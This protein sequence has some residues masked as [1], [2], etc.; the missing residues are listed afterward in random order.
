M[1]LANQIVF[2]IKCK[3]ISATAETTTGSDWRQIR[4]SF[5]NFEKKFCGIEAIKNN[6]QK[7]VEGGDVCC[8][9]VSAYSL[10]LY[11]QSSIAMA[12]LS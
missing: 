8:I 4:F 6:Y 7:L 9:S 11:C 12:N 1:H 3:K 2:A 5:F 10:F